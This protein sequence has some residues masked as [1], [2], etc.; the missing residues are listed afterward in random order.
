MVTGWN[1]IKYALN[2]SAPYKKKHGMMVIGCL[3]DLKRSGDF[4]QSASVSKHQQHYSNSN[5]GVSPTNPKRIGIFATN[6]RIA[7]YISA[8]IHENYTML[9]M[10]GKPY[11]TLVVWNGISKTN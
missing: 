7:G 11:S 3:L 2:Q 8:K 4:M 9:S 6:D 1:A 5:P 10:P